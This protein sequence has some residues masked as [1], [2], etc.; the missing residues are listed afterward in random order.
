MS[1]TV[2]ILVEQLKLGIMKLLVQESY[3]W[4]QAS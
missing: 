1:V 2:P 3:V 4:L